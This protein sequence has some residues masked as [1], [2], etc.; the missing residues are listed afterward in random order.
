MTRAPLG[1]GP[2]FLLVGCI[3]LKAVEDPDAPD[4]NQVGTTLLVAVG[5]GSPPE[6]IV[7]PGFEPLDRLVVTDGRRFFRLAY[8]VEPAA[9]G[10]QA[11]PVEPPAPDDPLQQPLSEPDFA[12][13]LEDEGWVLEAGLPDSLQSIRVPG[14]DMVGCAS[15]GGCYLSPEALQN[16]AC[17]LDCAQ[18]LAVEP[19]PPSLP[20]SALPGCPAPRSLVSED[21]SIRPA[22]GE[23]TH[24]RC[25]APVRPDCSAAARATVNGD[26]APR[27][28][29][30]DDAWTA[31]VG[32]ADFWVGTRPAGAL[33]GPLRTTLQAALAEAGEEAV[34]AV[35]GDHTVAGT[36]PRV[37]LQGRC[38]EQSSVR[39]R[40][41][42]APS[43]LTMD[44]LSLRPEGSFDGQLRLEDGELALV[45]AVAGGDWTVVRSRASGAADL[46]VT[47][48]QFV[49]SEIALGRVN[50]MG[51]LD[52]LDVVARIDGLTVGGDWVLTGSE[53]VLGQLSMSGSW[54]AED[55]LL[56][57]PVPGNAFDVGVLSWTDVSLDLEGDGESLMVLR[58]GGQ[59]E[60]VAATRTDGFPA[61]LLIDAEARLDVSSSSFRNVE[62]FAIG[63]LNLTDVST[64]GAGRAA[65]IRVEGGQLTARR[66]ALVVPDVALALRLGAQV[67]ISDLA[68][69][70]SRCEPIAIG[71]API[72]SDAEDAARG[73]RP[74]VA[75]AFAGRSIPEDDENTVR[76]VR[77]AIQDDSFVDFLKSQ[78]QV[79][80][81]GRFEGEDLWLARSPGRGLLFQGAMDVDLERV[82]VQESA[83]LGAC[84]FPGLRFEA[85]PVDAGPRGQSRVRL[86]D[87]RVEDMNVGVML[88]EDDRAVRPLDIEFDGL[89]VRRADVG[90][91]RATVQDKTSGLGIDLDKWLL[92]GAFSEVDLLSSG[93][94]N[95]ACD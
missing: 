64:F 30:G 78:V 27:I 8:R 40:N 70:G 32:A 58:R 6:L 67:D 81:L 49:D 91:V 73:A 68:I 51:G 7:Y 26:C 12:H 61:L 50:V 24:A 69:S 4:P 60:R 93:S 37:R 90:V 75:A 19:E 38:P 34:I 79:V 86:R 2:L 92:R 57:G 66:L 5:G 74:C 80:G 47:E 59:M 54:T 10:L 36:L 15:A 53:L 21:F 35:S 89:T 87:V 77:M 18:S 84:F 9:L 72:R 43:G 17:S 41:A 85:F 88:L 11:G 83:L 28:D 39:L 25:V 33:G 71:A 42:S 16:S 45:Q 22:G 3:E 76:I 23:L 46:S 52:M 56:R 29:C 95:D 44:H 20:L 13:R 55:S 94:L 62:L 1:L 14:T 82:L 63:E 31:R 65:S 48:L